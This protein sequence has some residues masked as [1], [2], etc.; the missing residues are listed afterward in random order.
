M[1][2]ALN[3]E[4]YCLV[5]LDYGIRIASGLGCLIESIKKRG[6]KF[7][8]MTKNELIKYFVYSK[9]P[10]I[11]TIGFIFILDHFIVIHDGFGMNWDH[12]FK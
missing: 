10:F 11:S 7:N 4:T 12:V 5:G 3:S 6:L 8:K 9:F 1:F 2:K